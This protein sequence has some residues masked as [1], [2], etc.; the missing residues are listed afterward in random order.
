M[1]KFFRRPPHAPLVGEWWIAAV[2]SYTSG[3][4]RD[5]DEEHPAFST[6]LNGLNSS[7]PRSARRINKM[8]LFSNRFSFSIAWYY[9]EVMECV[10][11]LKYMCQDLEENA[12]KEEIERYHCVERVLYLAVIICWV[13]H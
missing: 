10:S 4:E 11:V 3:C 12:N 6:K 9:V 7:R 5:E 1:A 2:D 13:Q 8:C